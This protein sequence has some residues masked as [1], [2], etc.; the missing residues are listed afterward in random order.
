[1]NYKELDALKQ[2]TEQVQDYIETRK[3]L[4]A[5]GRETP[6]LAYLLCEKFCTGVVLA[7]Q[8]LAGQDAT[9]RLLEV[10]HQKLDNIDAHW[11]ENSRR[12]RAARPAGLNCPNQTSE[13]IPKTRSLDQ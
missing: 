6:E 13:E 3:K 11:L 1:M 7:V 4:V 5:A 9:S 2:L 12:R 10:I 8:L